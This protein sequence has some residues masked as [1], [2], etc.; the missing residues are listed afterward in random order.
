MKVKVTVYQKESEAILKA[1]EK[2]LLG[3]LKYS[4]IAMPFDLTAAVLLGYMALIKLRFPINALIGCAG[5]VLLCER[6]C[7]LR[8]RL[9]AIKFFLGFLSEVLALVQ[10]HETFTL[11]VPDKFGMYMISRL[12]MIKSMEPAEKLLPAQD[13]DEASEKDVEHFKHMF[14]VHKKDAEPENL[15]RQELL[16]F[17]ESHGHTINMTRRKREAIIDAVLSSPDSGKTKSDV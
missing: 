17:A 16:K 9:R 3:R 5:P 13:T 12:L 2:R 8:Y 14:K 4:L 15:S 1:N 6:F 11:E 7:R 10:K